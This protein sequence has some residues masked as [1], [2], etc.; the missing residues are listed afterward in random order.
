MKSEWKALCKSPEMSVEDAG[1]VVTF[2]DQR[3]HRVAVTDGDDDLLLQAV[4]ARPSIVRD[5]GN[6]LS[7][8][9]WLRNRSVALVGFRIDE[10]ERLIC[11]AVVPKAGLTAD[12]FQF[13]LR[14]VAVEADRFEYALTGR[15]A[16]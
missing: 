13:H 12:E 16:E 9:A 14:T 5:I 15:D 3:K 8:T 1:V 11:E 6:A 7:V 4:V 10:K 2:H